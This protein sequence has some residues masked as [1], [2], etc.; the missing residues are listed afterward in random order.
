MNRQQFQANLASYWHGRLQQFYPETVSDACYEVWDDISMV[1]NSLNPNL[2]A[3]Q[4]YSI[5]YTYPDHIKIT[6]TSEPDKKT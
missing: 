2:L 1:V 4:R 5:F 6:F 3:K